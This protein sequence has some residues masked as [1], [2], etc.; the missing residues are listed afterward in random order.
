MKKCS[1]IL[2]AFALILSFGCDKNDDDPKEKQLPPITTEGKNTFGCKI[3]GELFIADVNFSVGGPMP[4]VAYRQDSNRFV[5]Q[6]TQEENDQL[7]D[8]KIR[9]YIDFTSSTQTMSA[10]S[11]SVIGYTDY[12]LIGTTCADYYYDTSNLGTINV[13]H[14]DT[15]NHIFSGTFQM[16]LLNNSCSP[17]Q[18]HITHGRFDVQ[19][20]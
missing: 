14:L 1:S 3:D 4:V 7:K 19:Y 17:N 13:I 6:G 9:S 5:I 10:N 15:L 2:L 16:V 11:S 18:I 8:V 20:Q 12:S